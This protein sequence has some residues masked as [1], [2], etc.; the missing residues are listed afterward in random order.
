MADFGGAD[1]DAFR[2]EAKTWLEANFP[3]EF[4]NDPQRQMRA[5]TTTERDEAWDQWRQRI[6]E[7][8]WGTPPWPKEDGGG[9]VSRQEAR[10]SAEEMAKIGARNPIDGMGVMMFGP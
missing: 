8:G 5:L 1:L 9:G 6:D 4:R 3:A 7:K 2:Q 10:I